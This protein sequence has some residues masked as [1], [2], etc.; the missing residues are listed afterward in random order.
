MRQGKSLC[1]SCY[2]PKDELYFRALN[3][4]TK[5]HLEQVYSKSNECIMGEKNSYHKLIVTRDFGIARHPCSRGCIP[6]R[7]RNKRVMS[8][9][10]LCPKIFSMTNQF[11]QS[12]HLAVQ[13]VQ[14]LYFEDS[15]MNLQ[16]MHNCTFGSNWAHFHLI[17][18]SLTHG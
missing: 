13:H 14:K 18:Y 2:R 15:I 6:L 9:I 8:S 7:S 12:L 5:L 1:G 17:F 4:D 11:G 3:E 10:N 16:K